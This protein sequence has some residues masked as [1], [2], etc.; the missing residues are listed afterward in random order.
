MNGPDLLLGV[1]LLGAA[2]LAFKLVGP[3]SA[4]R[5]RLSPAVAR[6]FELLPTALITGLVVTQTFDAGRIDAKVVG[7]F[8]AVVAVVVRAPFPVVVVVGAVS[9][10]GLRAIGMP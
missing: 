5:L 6:L 9:A 3:L 2:T 4:E 7:V 1:L 10:A 8:A